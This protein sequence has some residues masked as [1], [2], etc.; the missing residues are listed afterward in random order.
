[1]MK[2]LRQRAEM[3]CCPGWVS[4]VVFVVLSLWTANGAALTPP[5]GTL[6][7]NTATVNY[8]DA[9]ENPL[10]SAASNTVSITLSGAPLLRIEKTAD[11]NPVAAGATFNYTLRYRNTGNAPATGVTVVD[12]LPTDVTFESASAAGAYSSSTHSVT[13]NLGAVASGV[14]GILTV[15]VKAGE[16]LSVGTS[17]VN[18]AA[19]TCTE[20]AGDVAALQ[21]LIGSGSNL[22]LEKSGAPPTVLPG[23]RIYYRI[24][25]HNIGNQEAK[26]VRITDSIP[27]GTSYVADSATSAG[28]LQSG[29]LSWTIGS[30]PA[31]SRG[32][33]GF[34]VRVSPL[35]VSGQQISNIAT[36]ITADE[37]KASNMT[38][39]TVS[40][41]SLL[42]LKMDAP[43]PV[44]AGTAIT[45]TL[46][47][48]N[49]G[50]LPLTGVVLS[51]VLP[52]ETSYLADDSGGVVLAGGSQVEWA[53]G[54]LAAGETKTVFLTV[55]T[56]PSLAQGHIIENTASVRT[57]E[58][59]AH[60]VRTVTTV[61][62][63]TAGQVAFFNASWQPV[64]GYRSGDAI[65]IQVDDPDQNVDP[66]LAETVTVV[67]VN[68]I[69]GDTET[70]IL[71][72]TGLNTGI[73]RGSMATTAA[74]TAHESGDLTVPPD[75]RVRVTYTDPL[76]AAPVSS[77]S[78]LID[79]LGVVFDSVTGTPVAGAMV[80]LRNWDAVADACDLASW[81][82]LPPGEVNPAAPTGADGKFAF[83]LV[84]PG[85]FC[86]QVAPPAGYTYPSVVPDADLPAGFTIGNGSRG[87]KF[88]LN[89][90]DPPLI[91]DI[92]LDP[93]SGRLTITK[94]GNKRA[95][96][97][98]DMIGY[99]LK[100]SNNGEAPVTAMTITDV[101]PHGIQYLA[102]SSRIDG[103]ALPDPRVLGNRTFAWD[104]AGLPPGAS[105]EIAYRA[106]AGPDSPRGDGINRAV[107]S[108]MS[109]GE[110]VAS[111]TA[112]FK[113]EITAGIFTE[114]GT[115]LG[116]IFLD[117]DGNR[118]Q[119]QDVHTG[120]WEPGISNVTLYL[121]DGTRVI[122]DK[123]GKYSILGVLPGTHVLRVD[124]TTL[125][126][127]LILVPL[128]N[129][130][131]GDASSQIVPM[132]PGGLVQADFAVVAIDGGPWDGEPDVTGEMLLPSGVSTSGQS[133]TAPA[134]DGQ[135]LHPSVEAH[136]PPLPATICSDDV[137]GT[138][139]VQY[140]RFVSAPAVEEPVEDTARAIQQTVGDWEER[141]KS[142]A[143]DLAFLSPAD[144][145]AALRK[146]IRV[147]LKAPLGTE[148]TLSVNGKTVPSRQIGRKMEDAGARVTLYE[149]IGV[150][151]IG[152]ESNL[153]AAEARD[154]F[155]IVRGFAKITVTSAGRPERISITTDREEI[156]ADGAS[157]MRVEV[158]LWDKLDQIIPYEG[159]A[160]VSLSA[161]AIVE[162]DADPSRE[163]FQ[164][165]LSE[166][167]AA[168]TIR[169]PHET[170]KAS[171]EV[172]LDGHSEA[173]D[174]FF[175][176]HLRN[177]FLVGMGEA[178]IGRGRGTGSFGYLKDD[179]W[180]DDGLYHGGKGAFFL[181]G[182]IYQDF[183]LTAAFDSDKKK[184]DDL[185]RENDTTL[186]S[187][188]KY[189]IYGDESTTG[190][191][192]SS[193]N[194]L[195]LKV[196]KNRSYLLY[197]D[198]KTELDETRLASYTRSFTGLK[199]EL[200]TSRFKVKAYGSYTEQTQV[201]DALPGRG[202]SGYYYLTK[203]PII[204][205][206]ERVTLEVRDRNRP[207]RVLSREGKSRGSDYEIDYSMGSI[208][209][210]ESVP[211]R[212][213]DYN[214]VYIVVSY[215]SRMEGDKYY[216]Y[217]GRGAFR[218]VPWME[219]GATGIVEEQAI[220]DYHL[221]GMDLTLNLPLKTN[222]KV[223]HART[224]G[225]F[226]ESGIF[227]RHS[228]QGWSLGLESE[229]LEKLRLGAYYQNLGDY[230]LNLS[231]VDAPR[232][233]T[234]HGLDAVYQLY[235][236]IHLR[237]R[238][239]DER[240]DLNSIKHRMAA[241]GM[242]AQF[243]KT[244]VEAEISNE[245]SSETYVPKVA[246]R[247]P[248]DIAETPH[249]LTA[250]KIGV[251][252]ELRDDLSM[253]VSHKQNLT[254]ESYHTSQAGLNYRI[255]EANR[256]YLR[257]EYQKYQDSNELRTLFGVESQV[258]STT[259][260]YNEYRLANGADGSRNQSVL[261][262]R[263]KLYIREGLTG[264]ASAEYLKT[265]KGAE[266]ENEPDALAGALGLE[267]LA[268][269]DFKVTGRFEHRREFSNN[270][271]KSYMAE[272]GL[273]YKLNPDYSLLLRER[274]FTE[275]D[276]AS[277]RTTTSRAMVGL[278]YRPI[279]SNRFNALM[280][281][282][283]KHQANSSTS[284]DVR[285]NAWI[286]S[287]EGVWQATVRLQ[288]AGKYA[289][290]F[291]R[292]GG[293]SSYT[294]L[295]SGRFLYD[296]TDRWDVGAEYRIL[297]SHRVKSRLQG[298]SIEVGYRIIK[299]LWIAGGYSFDTFDADLAGD[300]YQGKG[301]YMKLRVKFSED[302]LKG[303]FRSER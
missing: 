296:V 23:G 2:F 268:R 46:Q 257:E 4:A 188:D 55:L 61:N 250:A 115:I 9:N 204:E 249:E 207:D 74:A 14:G 177:L 141:I 16:G 161:G 290:K 237:G 187:E 216:L 80:T 12:S 235:Q 184:R 211:S 49:S 91:R 106:V 31:G 242:A 104:I 119:N 154:S 254:K 27:S 294:D 139:A 256:L 288:I 222:L 253:T 262:L 274:F 70:V 128:S 123:S 226:E 25:Y 89:V 195:Y 295:V 52:S 166:G 98:G 73:F 227:R 105:L 24:F 60:T 202:I 150:K 13:W 213:S 140:E 66:N 10:S 153:L 173:K 240:D 267:Y 138:P 148:T 129:R 103:Q 189:P 87:E 197:G 157:L 30:V 113:V 20:G 259:T 283:H 42:L 32:E 40:T 248:F 280:K 233:S 65:Y 84:P 38:V 48:E 206:S 266:R 7:V 298:G 41:Q 156:P 160:T 33:V 219:I 285:E 192:A 279:H 230:F 58:T 229:P 71:T 155:G 152:G 169:A 214:P 142:M 301:P 297:Q 76:D 277:G 190:Y 243:K 209:F 51:D 151:L 68:T 145:S 35:A 45:Y 37:A 291:T 186:D 108:G 96:A 170:G 282:E 278:A 77:A 236:D 234:K 199:Y 178:V 109:L 86:F 124:E 194:S 117:R 133:T 90:G 47:M 79:P 263:N 247:K 67:L 15:T 228:D 54:A 116:K 255:N 147:V 200:D 158:S 99:S 111:N 21:T 164:V 221:L 57:N 101:M 167:I 272:V 245:S 93:P 112:S 287:G 126:D 183:L 132:Q 276:G 223:E 261:G 220:G 212:D 149:Y 56:D 163:G 83:P 62:A 5:P 292:D 130:F 44:R 281:A 135:T 107:A 146:H 193:T 34:Q 94:T 144:G 97:I 82:A 69:S 293:F 26:L 198:Y 201:M 136:H 127:G 78:A 300:N 264:N 215:E 203:G 172:S 36:I 171:I 270:G 165:A 88:T 114:K 6:I 271:R 191:E 179:T 102:G 246:S 218:P 251:E 225:A 180:F 239:F 299:N 53:I 85:D 28:T 81:P 143:P 260:A 100:L 185:F 43:D 134:G 29:V 11:S 59:G 196:E 17:I 8:G 120:A 303:I 168:F 174:V 110:T 182:N 302:T 95:A 231:A 125:P 122:T 121:Q 232:G 238:Y 137:S 210:K 22:V 205:G 208:L 3:R 131:L 289:G 75:S 181:K 265:I 39:T 159:L 19:I 284:P 50:S 1:M 273:A 217:G 72:E 258:S 162:R 244:K 118:M 224:M 64:Y 63:R 92:P 275:D 252:T 175:S 286:F 176:P 269:E 18:N 241:I